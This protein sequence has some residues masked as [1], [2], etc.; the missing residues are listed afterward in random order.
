MNNLY[1][2]NIKRKG[3]NFFIIFLLLVLIFF[4]VITNSYRNEILYNLLVVTVLNIFIIAIFELW[5]TTEVKLN[6]NEKTVLSFLSYLLMKNGF[7]ENQIY[8]FIL[9]YFKAYSKKD[10]DIAIKKVDGMSM[11]NFYF[12]W[13][14]AFY[15][16]YVLFIII[17]IL[18]ENNIRNVF[19]E[20]DL[21]SASKRIV[22]NFETYKK[23]EKNY[24]KEID[25]YDFNLQRW[26]AFKSVGILPER[27]NLVVKKA[28]SKSN[29][30]Y[31]ENS[32][33]NAKYISLSNVYLS[34]CYKYTERKNLN[35]VKIVW[36]IIS[37]LSIFFN[38]YPYFIA[39]FILLADILSNAKYS[40]EISNFS[41]KTN[42]KIPDYFEILKTQLIINFLTDRYEI[43]GNKLVKY[44]EKYINGINRTEIYNI[45]TEKTPLNNICNEINKL[46]ID[47]KKF[48]KVLFD[49][50]AADNVFSDKEDEYIYMVA[51][52]LNIPKTDIDAIRD[53][54][55]KRGVTEKKIKQ[56]Q[57]KNASSSSSQGIYVFYSAKAYKI[58]GVEKSA[59]NDEIKKAYRK[60]VMLHHPDK[61]ATQ[62]KEA[63]ENAEEKFQ[64]ITEAYELIK[65]I[66]SIK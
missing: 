27:N 60:L 36:I 9:P 24:K 31:D 47:K 35:I 20:Y 56:E 4:I 22:G 26:N 18:Y 37:I 30:K 21:K 11:Q 64:I 62:G 57:Y 23:F 29:L 48:I 61:F 38:F 6:K 46:N 55:I 63:M 34:D 5:Q 32:Q 53:G 16:N 19:N 65:R 66:R 15:K 3:I 28:I 43:E 52:K 45:I 10:I 49:I 17:D 7:S 41:V 40:A 59:T 13:G 25:K 54:Y 50:A 39:L 2:M 58:L 42:S 1:Y 12:Y 14:G 8:K 51:K 33:K 44:V